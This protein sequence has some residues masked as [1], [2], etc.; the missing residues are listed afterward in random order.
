MSGK[1]KRYIFLFLAGVGLYGLYFG[2]MILLGQPLWVLLLVYTAIIAIFYFLNRSSI[3]ALR[4]NYFYVMGHRAQAKVL[5]RKAV[6]AGTKS[7]SAYIYLALMA[8]QEDRNAKEA[9]ALL[10]KARKLSVSIVDERNA[11]TTLASC[12]YLTGDTAK[13]IQVLEDMRAKHEYTSAGVLTTLGYMYFTLGDFDKATEFSHL[14]MEDDPAHGAAW[15][16]M[17][18]IYHKQGDLEAAKENF[19]TALSKRENLVD[20]NY[21]LGLIYET[22]GNPDDAKEYFRRASICTVSVYNTVT[23]EM[24]KEKYDKYYGNNE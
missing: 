16:N 8:V 2:I 17:G 19:R 1:V 23:D 9:F 10:E 6:D 4:G 21:H 18:Q 20:S 14:A 7:P 24:V 15:D 5:L 13:G 3:W 12:H 22:E 11:L